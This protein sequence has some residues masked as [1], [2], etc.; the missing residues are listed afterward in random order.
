[1]NSISFSD[2][3]NLLFRPTQTVAAGGDPK[4]VLCAF[5]VQGTCQKGTKCKFSHDLTLAN[6]SEKKSLYTDQRD[7]D[8]EGEKKPEEGMDGLVFQYFCNLVYNNK[9]KI[10]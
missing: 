6:K 10:C 2:E 9:E 3:L 1:M 8:E 4:S 5:F 7:G